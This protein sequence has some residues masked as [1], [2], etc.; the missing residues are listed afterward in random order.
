VSETPAR[1]ARGEQE[2][3]AESLSLVTVEWLATTAG[4]DEISITRDL[5]A[6]AR[7]RAALYQVTVTDG[8]DP[9]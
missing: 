4:L 1:S 7:N 3:A 6:A 8:V 5:I 9:S 2:S